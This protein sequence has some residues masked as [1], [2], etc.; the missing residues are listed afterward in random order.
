MECPLLQVQETHSLFRLFATS[1]IGFYYNIKYNIDTPF[2]FLCLIAK[3]LLTMQ[4]RHPSP[5]DLDVISLTNN[6]PLHTWL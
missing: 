3:H 6:F 5:F 1:D 2:T 4:I